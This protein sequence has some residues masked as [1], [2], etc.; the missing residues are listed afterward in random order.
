M[1]TGRALR[2]ISI[3]GVIVH[4]LFLILLCPFTALLENRER[5]LARQQD[6]DDPDYVLYE[7][8]LIRGV[9]VVG[10]PF[11]I[12]LPTAVIGLIISLV[13]RRRKSPEPSS[14][15]VFGPS[16]GILTIVYMLLWSWFLFSP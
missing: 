11:V 15:T 12:Y 7:E 4:L 5:Y 9:A 6:L 8:G 13:W 14:L 2:W 16:L 3:I 10:I 1:K